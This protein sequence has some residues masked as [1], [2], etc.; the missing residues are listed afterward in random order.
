MT[1]SPTRILP[2]LLAV[3]AVCLAGFV[4]LP[5]SVAAMATCDD[6]L[7]VECGQYSGLSDTD[8]RVTVPRIVNGAL[9]LLG[10][11][12]TM[13]VL[14]AGFLWMT[15]AGNEEKATQAKSILTTSVIG[16]I[17]IMMAY[18]ISRFVI[19]ESYRATTGGPYENNQYGPIP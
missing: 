13:L 10:T 16:L 15:A 9:G 4:L 1:F 11:V 8:P 5:R 19:S 2:W 7:G 17:I 3:T 12:A 6:P 18:S 14:Y